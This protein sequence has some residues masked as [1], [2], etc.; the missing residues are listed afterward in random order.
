MKTELNYEHVTLVTLLFVITSLDVANTNSLPGEFDGGLWAAVQED[1]FGI[2]ILFHA[3]LFHFSHKVDI[4]AQLQ[5]AVHVWQLSEHD[6][7]VLIGC[8]QAKQ[9]TNQK[10][11]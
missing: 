6:G 7:H 4:Q 3:E 5:E 9:S 1:E 11:E 10:D 2:E 8:A